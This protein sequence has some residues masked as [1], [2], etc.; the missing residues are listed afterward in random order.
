[1]N[2]VLSM[3]LISVTVINIYLFFSLKLEHITLAKRLNLMA[4]KKDLNEIRREVRS[5]RAP[6]PLKGEVHLY[7]RGQTAKV[8]ASFLPQVYRG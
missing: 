7:Y 3:L 5:G 2:F 8:K 1:M 6:R 4:R